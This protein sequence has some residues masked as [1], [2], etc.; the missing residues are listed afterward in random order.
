MDLESVLDL[1]GNDVVAEVGREA[2]AV[3]EEVRDGLTGQNP[4][5]LTA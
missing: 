4:V 2:R 5:R 3:I 1:A